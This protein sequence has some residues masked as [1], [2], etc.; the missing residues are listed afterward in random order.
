MNRRVFLIALFALMATPAIPVRSQG[1][2]LLA[3]WVVDIETKSSPNIFRYKGAKLTPVYVARVNLLEARKDAQPTTYELFWGARGKT[4]ALERRSEFNIPKN[5]GVQFKLSHKSDTAPYA[6]T[7]LA[8]D[9]MLRVLLDLQLNANP[10][11]AARVPSDSFDDVVN[12]LQERE[13]ALKSN[14]PE[15]PLQ[16][17]LVI[18]IFDENGRHADLFYPY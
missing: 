16:S 11:F 4:M 8:V 18:S 15:T 7:Q 9:A 13:F 14:G 10:V 1:T 12:A 17:S 3:Q 6:E 2:D 5:Q